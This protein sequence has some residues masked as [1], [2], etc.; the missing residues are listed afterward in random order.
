MGFLKNIS[1]IKTGYVHTVELKSDGSRVYA[2][3]IN[4]FGQIGDGTTNNS[5]I[6]IEVLGV[7]GTGFLQNIS[8]IAGG[9]AHSIAMTTGDAAVY[10]WG[11][12]A[13]GQ[14]GEGTTSDSTSPK[15]VI[16]D[17]APLVINGVF[18]P[19]TSTVEYSGSVPSVNTRVNNPTYYNLR[20]NNAG[21]TYVP[22]GPVVVNGSLNLISGTY[23]PAYN[24]TTV[25]TMTFSGPVTPTDSVEFN[26]GNSTMTFNNIL[27]AGV[28]ALTLTADSI[29]F[30]GGAGSVSGTGS[31][32][33]Q[34]AAAG[35]SIG[36]AGAA[37]TMQIPIPTALVDGFSNIIIGRADGTGLVTVNAISFSDPV[38][39]RSPMA[40]GAIQVDGEI[41]GTGNSSITLTT[42]GNVTFGAAGAVNTPNDATLTATNGSVLG[43]AAALT[44]VTA[45][46]LTIT[47]LGGVGTAVDALETNVTTLTANVTAA[48]IINVEEF[49][50]I[51]LANV[52][53]FSGSVNVV[54]GGDMSVDVV[55]AVGDT[56]TLDSAGAIE[57]SGA[58]AA[59]DLVATDADLTSVNGIGEAGTLEVDFSMNSATFKVTG[60]GGINVKDTSGGLGVASATTVNG[61]ITLES[62]GGDL[63]LTTVTAGG[64][65]RNVILTTTTSGDVNVDNVAAAGDTVTI[66]SAGKI[67]E[68][69]TDLGVDLA[70]G[71]GN[72]TAAGSI[73]NPGPIE[74]C[75]DTITATVTGVGNIALNECDGCAAS[76]STAAG[77]INFTAGGDITAG[78]ITATGGSFTVSTTG[79]GSILDGNGPLVNFTSSANSTLTAS[80]L[81]GTIGTALNAV[82]ANVTGGTLTVIAPG[83]AGGVSVNM[84]GTVWPVNTLTLFGTY[85]GAV[86]WNGVNLLIVAETIQAQI[87]VAASELIND[88][89]ERRMFYVDE[90]FQ[91]FYLELPNYDYIHRKKVGKKK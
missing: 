68:I 49:D 47:S 67:E 55:S 11:Y 53:T 40:G 26:S 27:A 31:I 17:A 56:I 16:F 84:T 63:N 78:A 44:N 86:Y 43:D 50:A 14:L 22:A 10:A 20:I 79:G 61:A 88:S 5:L 66:N 59:A 13:Y 42:D 46:N 72:F 1:F 70:G 8:K 41:T 32:T 29:S 75:F 76:L 57:E 7:G 77:N 54:S 3:G 28:N 64:V 71:I 82:E 62:V 73:G 52:T 12:N 21:E 33:L 51:T 69:G 60:T 48:G 36:I 4:N 34:P 87:A 39:I 89:L 37:G 38:T 65:G 80:G 30:S 35:T 83:A 74:V 6:P 25:G 15:Q 91:M 19:Q 18:D 2:W 9:G 23:A 81:A 58:D 85:N 90:N 45:N 24:T